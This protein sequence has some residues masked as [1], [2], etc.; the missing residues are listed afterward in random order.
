MKITRK[1]SLVERNDIVDKSERCLWTNDGKPGLDYLMNS[2]VL[3]VDTIK[4]FRLGYIPHSVHHQLAGRIIFP[5]YDPSDNLI[6]ISSRDIGIKK[7]NLPVYWHESYEKSWYLYGIKQA[8]ETILEWRFAIV[9]EGQIDVLQLHNHD[10]RNAVGLCGTKLSDM[11]IAMIH[12]YCK[13]IVILLDEDENLSGQK[14]IKK[15]IDDNQGYKIISASFGENT[16]PDKFI[17]DKGISVLK[18]IVKNK[19]SAVRGNYVC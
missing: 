3:S 9:V 6:C 16:D 4:R 15:I 17:R 11:Q 19:L 18:K 7:T 5:L 12:R 14:G 13:E 10:M 8:K 1:F 2:R